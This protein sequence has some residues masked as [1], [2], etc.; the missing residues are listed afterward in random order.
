MQNSVLGAA[1]YDEPPGSA[2]DHPVVIGSVKIA[3]PVTAGTRDSRGGRPVA[4][5]RRRFAGV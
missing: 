1:E 3:S 5:E 2:L 4:D